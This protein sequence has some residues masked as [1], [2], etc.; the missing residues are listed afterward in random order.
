MGVGGSITFEST[1]APPP[2]NEVFCWSF[3]GR[4]H[5]FSLFSLM[6]P[7]SRVWVILHACKFFSRDRCFQGCTSGGSR[8][9]WH[10]QTFCESAQRCLIH[11]TNWF[12]GQQKGPQFRKKYHFAKPKIRN[13]QKQQGAKTTYKSHFCVLHPVGPRSKIWWK[14]VQLGYTPLQKNWMCATGCFLRLA[15]LI[16]QLTFVKYFLWYF[17]AFSSMFWVNLNRVS[18]CSL[19]WRFGGVFRMCFDRFCMRGNSCYKLCFLLLQQFLYVTE[20]FNCSTFVCS[21]LVIREKLVID[22]YYRYESRCLI[23]KGR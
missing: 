15:V 13:E 14:S 10:P 23:S 22:T 9:V 18:I 3:A 5:T 8:G 20:Q 6:C 16:H 2:P 4:G 11:E 21:S 7:F 17:Y 19:Q 12:T 1:N